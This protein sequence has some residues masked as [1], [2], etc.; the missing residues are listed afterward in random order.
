MSA[1]Y[2][3]LA[4]K[5]ATSIQDQIAKAFDMQIAIMRGSP[6]AEVEQRRIAVI[7]TAEAYADLM[8]EAAK[9]R[10]KALQES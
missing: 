9:A 2:R 4:V 7:L 1:D 8:A 6:D 3:D 10:L 5:A